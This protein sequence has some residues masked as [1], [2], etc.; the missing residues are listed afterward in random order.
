[1][2]AMHRRRKCAECGKPLGSTV[3]ECY[4]CGGEKPDRDNPAEQW[5]VEWKVWLGVP[6]NKIQAAHDE[7][8]WDHEYAR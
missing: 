3:A 2:T 8:D 6:W 5:A 1:M 4:E 7:G